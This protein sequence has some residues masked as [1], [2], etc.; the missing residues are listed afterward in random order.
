MYLP[1]SPL[2]PPL[3]LSMFTAA[4]SSLPPGSG[5]S[6]LVPQARSRSRDELAALL[7][8]LHDDLMNQVGRAMVCVCVRVCVC[9]LKSTRK[10]LR[11]DSVCDVCVQRITRELRAYICVCMCV[12]AGRGS[13]AGWCMPKRTVC[14]TRHHRQDP[15]PDAARPPA[16]IHGEVSDFWGVLEACAASRH[17]ELLSALNTHLAALSRWGRAGMGWGGAGRA[18]SHAGGGGVYARARRGGG[19]ICVCVWGGGA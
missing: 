14:R 15:A 16:Q 7:L 2:P 9:A 13:C 1:S 17:A 6:A 12:W 18:P 11:K 3:S 10:T 8:D 4:S 5:P 19:G